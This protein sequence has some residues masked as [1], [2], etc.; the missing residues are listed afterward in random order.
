MTSNIVRGHSS[1]D[2]S[3]ED[4]F[5]KLSRL[6]RLQSLPTKTRT[7]ILPEE[8]LCVLYEATAEKAEP[9]STK[10]AA[11][12]SKRSW[13]RLC[14]IESFPKVGIDVTVY[15]FGAGWNAMLTFSPGS[16][17]GFRMHNLSE[18]FAKIGSRNAKSI[19]SSLISKF[20]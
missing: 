11:E 20:A 2:W 12:I 7:V 17:H 10:T 3:A 14:R 13:T 8:K 16:T 18:G 15:G 6:Q 5:S 9:R 19:L 1:V 4:I